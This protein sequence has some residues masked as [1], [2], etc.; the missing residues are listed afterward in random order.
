MS[1]RDLIELVKPKAAAQHVIFHSYDAYTTNVPLA[2][3]SADD[4]HAGLELERR[5]D[6]PRAWRAAARGDPQALFL[7][8]LQVDQAHRI[9]GARQAG[10]LG[11]ARLSRLR[12]SVARSSDTTEE[13]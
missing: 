9:L 12:R 6:Q 8:E 13:L 2:D 11:S 1:A 4:V 5:A 3:F 7:E 10:L